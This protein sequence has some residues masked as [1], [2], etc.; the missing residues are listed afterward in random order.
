MSRL[1]HEK[2]NT[3]ASH[4]PPNTELVVTI[5]GICLVQFLSSVAP[6]RHSG[7]IFPA[8]KGVANETL[9]EKS[10][11][12]HHSRVLEE[13]VACFAIGLSQVSLLLGIQYFHLLRIQYVHTVGNPICPH[14]WESNISTC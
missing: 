7:L 2:K 11:E 8:P 13:R 12:I 6:L 1:V 5:E 9:I 14:C 3:S 10:S 4:S